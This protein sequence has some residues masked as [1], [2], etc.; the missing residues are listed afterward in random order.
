R[1]PVILD[2]GSF[3]PFN[4]QNTAWL[5]G[6]YELMY[7][8]S[9]VSFRLGD[10]WRGF[11]AQI[12]LQAVGMNLSFHSPTVYQDRNTHDLMQDFLEETPGYLHNRKIMDT[13]L[14]LQ[15]SNKSNDLGMNLLKCWAALCGIGMVPKKEIDLCRAWL[16]E[17]E[18]CKKLPSQQNFGRRRE[19]SGGSSH[20]TNK[21]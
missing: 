21:G 6:A 12:C 10:I 13:L 8:P 9:H 18:V 1:S 3:C 4:S 16:K 14:S 2:K 7:I 19:F 20:A 15:L 5:F 17:L 11:V